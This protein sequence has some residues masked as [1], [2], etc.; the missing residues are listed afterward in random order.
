M[1]FATRLVVRYCIPGNIE[2]I[3]DGQVG[4]V[5]VRARYFT[6]AANPSSLGEHIEFNWS[7]DDYLRR[8]VGLGVLRRQ[9]FIL[10]MS[11]WGRASAARSGPG[12]NP[13]ESKNSCNL[14]PHKQYSQL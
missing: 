4:K 13:N 3:E 12:S 6:N 5:A 14:R 11:S 2:Q 10:E 1:R 7:R 8:V 9:I